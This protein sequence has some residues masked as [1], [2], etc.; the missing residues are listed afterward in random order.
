MS[1]AKPIAAAIAVL[2]AAGGAY[3]WYSS[4]STPVVGEITRPAPIAERPPAIEHPVAPSE[5]SD[6]LP[7]LADSDAYLQ[8][9][10]RALSG[11]APAP[12]DASRPNDAKEA[13]A[14]LP[15]GLRLDRL[16]RR[17][18]ASVDALTREGVPIDLRML[19]PVK[20][21][22]I[23]GGT[24]DAPVLDPKN[25]E[26]YEPYVRWLEKL[27]A[28]RVGETY[29]QAY[30]LLQAAYEELGYP[31]KYFNDRL[32]AV[33]DD[34]LAT[35]DVRGPIALA[36]PHVLY[37][38]ADAT[39]EQRSAGQKAMLRL[40]PERAARVKAKLKELRAVFAAEA[41]ADAGSTP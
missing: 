6:P 15:A 4:R 30:P 41:G 28:A 2:V 8:R 3:W 21:R 19:A 14:A 34:L 31:N 38:Y 16:A 10:L 40:G 37:V 1:P 27:D 9:Q 39:L 11:D 36:R 24:E 29:R 25:G 12:G 32:V 18:V 35:P 7:P 23:V 26:R 17:F 20:G 5:S 22:L 13:S 33:I